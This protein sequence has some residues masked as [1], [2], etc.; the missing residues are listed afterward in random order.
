MLFLKREKKKPPTIGEITGKLL[1][2]KQEER[3]IA[4]ERKTLTLHYKKWEHLNLH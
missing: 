3:K 1:E 2:S 4:T